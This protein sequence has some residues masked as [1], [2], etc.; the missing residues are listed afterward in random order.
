LLQHGRWQGAA[1]REGPM[2]FHGE[3]VTGC[4]G[5]TKGMFMGICL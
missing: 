1:E 2:T 3:A 4:F 5:G